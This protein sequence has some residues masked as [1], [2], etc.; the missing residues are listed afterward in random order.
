MNEPTAADQ[1]FLLLLLL[2]RVMFTPT[3]E[4][5]S[6]ATLIGLCI[7]T[8][9]LRSLPPRFK[10]D[11]LV[12]SCSSGGSVTLMC[13]GVTLMCPGYQ[14]PE[15]LQQSNCCGMNAFCCVSCSKQS[16]RFVVTSIRLS[17]QLAVLHVLPVLAST[18]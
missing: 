4:H 16:A 15:G 2:F 12:S 7:R 14:A 18:G 17:C 6:M 8:K 1:K 9:L 13:S 11:I 3:V 10:V 5:C